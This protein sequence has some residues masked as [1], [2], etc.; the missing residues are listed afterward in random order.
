MSDEIKSTGKS[1][2]VRLSELHIQYIPAFTPIELWNYDMSLINSPHVELMRDLLE[3]GFSWDRLKSGRYAQE[4]MRRFELGVKRWTEPYIIEHIKKRY[5]V[6]KSLKKHGYSKKRAVPPIQVLKEPLWKTRFG[7]S[8]PFL[9]GMEIYNGAGRCS[10]A[11]ALGWEEIPVEMVKD[12][13]KYGDKGK[14]EKKLRGINGI[15]GKE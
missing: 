1:V 10:A 13:K 3:N 11:V 7:C 6:L 15:W 12:A 14:F 9:N 5:D 2:K 4:R 8:E